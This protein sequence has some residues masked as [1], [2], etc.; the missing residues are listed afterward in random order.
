MFRID[1]IN[2]ARS[3]VQKMIDKEG[4]ILCKYDGISAPDLSELR[5]IVRKSGA[6]M[7]MGGNKV[8]KR[9]FEVSEQEG[10]M[11]F[12]FSKSMHNLKG[13]TAWLFFKDDLITPLGALTDAIKKHPG[14]LEVVGIQAG[15]QL[16]SLEL[17]SRISKYKSVGELWQ[18]V[19]STLMLPMSTLVILLKEYY[20]KT[21]REGT[22]MIDKN[23]IHGIT[24]EMNLD[25]NTKRLVSEVLELNQLKLF[26]FVGA[27][28]KVMESR[29]ISIGAAVS[30]SSASEPAE[31]QEKKEFKLKVVNIDGAD[32]LKAAKL[33]QELFEK[34]GKPIQKLIEASKMITASTVFDLNPIPTSE[35]EEWISKFA[36]L[37]VVM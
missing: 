31:E 37:G 2:F 36:E 4:V 20:N 6:L 29:G 3:F 1:K 33:V 24:E 8:V 22:E 35:A 10:Q 23:H 25:E 5:A 28:T 26:D 21:L 34:G 18:N 17:I 14:Q 11:K 27:L 19:Y 15:E 9:G 12:N 7:R 16:F 30:T 32:R 13:S